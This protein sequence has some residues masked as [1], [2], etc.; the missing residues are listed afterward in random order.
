MKVAIIGIG[1]MGTG[2]AK[3]LDKTKHQVFI[4]SRN[5]EKAK[6]MAQSLGNSQGGSY[7]DAAG[8]ADV[9]IL[10][11][12]WHSMKDV[13]NALGD[14]SGKVLVDICNPLT[15]DFSG[16]DVG[17][18]T[19]AAEEIAKIVPGA[20]VV[21]AFNTIFAEVLQSSH[22]FEEGLA[23]VFICGDDKDAKEMVSELARDSGYEP[24]DCG[25]LSAARWLEPLGMLNINLG[26]MQKMG[27]KIAFRL[28]RK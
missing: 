27:A 3:S 11:A 13:L 9:I 1:N 23:D 7:K 24:V 2:F 10:A 18:T 12:P 22:K 14:V 5:I 25:A 8:F 16:L 17:F 28:M 20:K 26:Y 21:K 6:E 4:G 15:K 19:S